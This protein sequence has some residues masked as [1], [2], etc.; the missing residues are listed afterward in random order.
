M[1]SIRKFMK[2][3]RLCEVE[4]KENHM[5]FQA[6]NA[7][8]K[9]GLIYKCLFS[10]MFNKLWTI[11]VREDKHLFAQAM[12]ISMSLILIENIKVK[13]NIQQIRYDWM[14]YCLF[15][16]RGCMCIVMLMFFLIVNSIAVWKYLFVPLI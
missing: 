4:S 3:P 2:K 12:K 5:C 9:Y 6:I 10:C 16:T 1:Y 13:Y 11:L 14:L 7:N 8:K 15:D